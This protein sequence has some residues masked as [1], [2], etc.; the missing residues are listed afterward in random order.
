M[1]KFLSMSIICLA[2]LLSAT[3]VCAKERG[4]RNYDG[5]TFR[6]TFRIANIDGPEIKG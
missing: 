6:A 2:L 1:M 5:D 3:Q 4:F